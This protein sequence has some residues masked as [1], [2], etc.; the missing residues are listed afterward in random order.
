MTTQQVRV[1]TARYQLSHTPRYLQHEAVGPDPLRYSLQLLN[2]LPQEPCQIKPIRPQT[3]FPIQFKKYLLT[4]CY[5]PG[6]IY[7]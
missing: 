7:L 5:R 4:V 6:V 2:W 1:R 3:A